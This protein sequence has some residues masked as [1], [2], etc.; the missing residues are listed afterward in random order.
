[1]PIE[2]LKSLGV[3]SRRIP[4]NGFAVAPA[5]FL[6]YRSGPEWNGTGQKLFPFRA[7]AT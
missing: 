2:D 5:L 1:M 6:G 7:V 4:L 3:L